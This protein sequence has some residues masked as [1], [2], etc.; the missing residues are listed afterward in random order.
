MLKKCFKNDVEKLKTVP[1]KRP[2]SVEI[3]PSN[4]GK[5]VWPDVWH[6]YLVELHLFDNAML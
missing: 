4:S 1:P 6:T 3:P 2:V 5:Q